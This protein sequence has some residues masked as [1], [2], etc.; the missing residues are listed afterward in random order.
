[1]SDNTQNDVNLLDLFAFFVKWRKFLFGII[2]GATIFAAIISFL[3]PPKYR[4]TAVI[5]S[6]EASSEGIGG[7]LVSKLA[8]LGGIGGL[9]SSLGEIPGEFLVLILKSRW[10]TEQLIEEFD[11]RSVYKMKDQPIEEVIVA[12]NAR[13]RFELDAESQSVA[14]YAEDRDPARARAMADFLVEQT[15]RRHQELRSYSARRER[16]FIG[17]RLEET[18][19]HLTALEDSLV[20]FQ[21]QTGVLD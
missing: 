20:R 12:A 9:G 5:R 10:M 19:A 7:L 17:Q 6:A 16:E 8:A 11:L 14:V 15:D 2:A 4:S 21:E 3:L 1:M 13:T 18:Q